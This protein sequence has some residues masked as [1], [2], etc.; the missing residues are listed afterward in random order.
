MLR[1]IDPNAAVKPTCVQLVQTP[2]MP[3]RD[4]FPRPALKSRVSTHRGAEARLD[5]T[6]RAYP[7]FGVS[8]TME[9][10][11]ALNALEVRLRLHGRAWMCN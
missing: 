9:Q 6:P 4:Y 1:M 3:W 11:K 2:G 8:A 5:S 10:T 7:C